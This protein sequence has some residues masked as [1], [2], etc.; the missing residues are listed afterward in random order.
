MYLAVLPV[1]IFVTPARAP[2]LVVLLLFWLVRKGLTGHWTIPTPLDWP[3]RL[4]ALMTLISLLVSFDFAFSFPRVVAVLYGLALIYALAWLSSRSPRHFAGSVA[5]FGLMGLGIATLSLLGT[6]WST[7]FGILAPLV[8]RLPH[9]LSLPGADDGFQANQVAGVLLWVA[10]LAV[11]LSYTAMMGRQTVRGDFLQRHTIRLLL[12]G[13][14][15]VMGLVLLLTQSRGGWLGFA[16]AMV[17]LLVLAVHRYR[18][19]AWGTP[20]LVALLVVIIIQQMGVERVQALLFD[21]RSENSESALESLSIRQEVWVRGWYAVQDFPLTGMGM[22][23]FRRVVPVLYPFFALSGVEDISHA[24]N[25]FLQAALD[26]GIPGLIGYL[27]L[28][29]GAVIMLW[30]S[31]RHTDEAWYRSCAAGFSACLLAYF[32]YGLTDAVAFGAKPGFLFWYL[33]G[34]VAGLHE[35]VVNRLPKGCGS[36]QLKGG[37]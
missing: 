19:L 23:T 11:A 29:L 17:L 34:L 7:K 12:L 15:G 5:L 31:W 8:N 14:T 16:A 4:L 6:S 13:G 37:E 2:I 27:G 18:W 32:I 25:Q 33:I 28:W 1:V 36:F 21:F 35:L 26:V 20:V 22:N 3:L 9:L 30:Q 24:H 10:P